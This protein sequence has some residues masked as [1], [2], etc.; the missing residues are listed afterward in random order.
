MTPS[1]YFTIPFKIN[2]IIIRANNKKDSNFKRLNI[3]WQEEK[4]K[5]PKKII[6][7]RYFLR[8]K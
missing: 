7:S 3:M 5:N 1:L 2:I 8:L 4:I 6:K